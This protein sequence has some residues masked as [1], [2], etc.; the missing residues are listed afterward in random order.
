MA[1]VPQEKMMT[2]DVVGSES[3]S[4]GEQ[5]ASG[6]PQRKGKPW[7]YKKPLGFLPAYATPKFQVFFVAMVCFLCPGMFNAVNVSL[8]ILPCRFSILDQN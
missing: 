7:M 1:D 6:T 3:P 5:E 2:T 4:V 8:H